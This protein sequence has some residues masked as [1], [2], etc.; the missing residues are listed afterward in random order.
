M[1]SEPVPRDAGDHLAACYS[2]HTDVYGRMYQNR[3]ARALTARCYGISNGQYGQPELDRAI[4]LGGPP[5][6]QSFPDPYQFFGTNV[7]Y[8][9]A[10]R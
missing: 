1:G 7:E 2:G 6:L 4:S 10:G 9:A 3:P 5:A 8:L